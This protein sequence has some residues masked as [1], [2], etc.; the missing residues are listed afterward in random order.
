MGNVQLTS[1]R[2]EVIVLM[3]AEGLGLLPRSGDNDGTWRSCQRCSSKAKDRKETGRDVV[4]Q[5]KDQGM[6][7]SLAQPGR[8]WY[9]PRDPKPCQTGGCNGSE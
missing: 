5:R 4:E 6:R 2:V 3:V 8:A 7:A 9:E 1:V